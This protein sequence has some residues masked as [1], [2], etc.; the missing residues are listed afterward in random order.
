MEGDQSSIVEMV[1]W[2]LV[3][4]GEEAYKGIQKNE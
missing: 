1:R 4:R 3:A 2:V